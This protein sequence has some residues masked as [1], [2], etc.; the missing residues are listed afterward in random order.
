MRMTADWAL[1]SHFHLENGTMN[2][3]IINFADV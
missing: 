3:S 2:D 1:T